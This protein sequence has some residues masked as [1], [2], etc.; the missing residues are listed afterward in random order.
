METTV[1]G[2]VYKSRPGLLLQFFERSRGN[3]K[4]RCKQAK[5]ELKLTKNQNRAV[6]KSRERWR[7]RVKELEVEMEQLQAELAE[8]KRQPR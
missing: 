1:N 3:W 7:T 6:E 4:R 5:A 8:Q 2:T